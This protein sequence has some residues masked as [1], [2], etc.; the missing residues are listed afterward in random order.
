MK[1]TSP[2]FGEFEYA[3][4]Q[5]I[6]F[7]KGLLGF[8]TFE[9]YVLKSLNKTE[10]IVWLLSVEE[11][12]PDF[13][14]IDPQL[15]DD[16][17]T[18]QSQHI[19]KSTLSRLHAAGEADLRMYC[20]VTVPEDIERISMNV[21]APILI[22]PKTKRGVQRLDTDMKTRAV[23]RPIY[24]ELTGGKVERTTG[25]LVLH[26]KLNETV[27]IGDDIVVEVIALEDGG[28][29]LGISAP[30]DI[31][32]ARGEHNVDPAEQMHQAE[33]PID[34]NALAAMLRESRAHVETAAG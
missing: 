32:I 21:R 18:V 27:R 23:R 33:K 15:I 28:V 3:V 25:Q 29:R 2:L 30:K 7:P 4:D 22:C 34:V 6:T 1:H 24:K 10:P 19:G 8:P 14:L 12:G 20:V 17:C 26:R 9:N 13:A 16:R 11:G 5:V 31:R